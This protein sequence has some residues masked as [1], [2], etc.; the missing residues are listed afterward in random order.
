M[1]DE[2]N[3]VVREL[4]GVAG[5]YRGE[6]PYEIMLIG[7]APGPT[8]A[9]QGRPFVGKAGQLLD[10]MLAD[11]GIDSYYITNVVKVFPGYDEKTRKIKK[12]KKEEKEYWKP[13]LD[14]EIEA[15]APTK[16]VLLGEH[17]FKPFFNFFG[18]NPKVGDV[19]GKKLELDGITYFYAYHPAGFLYAMGTTSNQR[20]M[21]TQRRLLR[22]VKG[23]ESVEY[24][25]EVLPPHEYKGTL[26]IDVETEGGTDPRSATITEWTVLSND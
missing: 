25:Y 16:I 19:V 8:E 14:A 6:G 17:A 18:G 3:A 21:N 5:E 22:D 10:T 9:K 2:I 1:L 23:V 15:V 11:A 26:I 20:N 13:Y 24:K 4:G 7:E 12:P